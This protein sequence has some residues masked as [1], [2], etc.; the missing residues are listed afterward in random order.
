MGATAKMQ[1]YIVMTD[2]RALVGDAMPSLTDR[3]SSRM[4]YGTIMIE[5]GSIQGVPSC[6]FVPATGMMMIMILMVICGGNNNYT[7]NRKLELLGGGGDSG[8]AAPSESRGEPSRGEQRE[9]TKTPKRAQL[10]SLSRNNASTYSKI[11]ANFSKINANTYAKIN[12]KIDAN[13]FLQNQ[14]IYIYI[15]IYIYIYLYKYIYINIYIYIYI[16]SILKIT[17]ADISKSYTC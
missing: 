6:V 12:A 7:Y 8:F 4:C 11:N 3:E 13:A 1:Q 10:L 5:F 14:Y 9:E 15:H 2:S 16:A 17:T